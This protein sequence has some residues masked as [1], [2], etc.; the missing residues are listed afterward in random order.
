MRIEPKIKNF[1][2]V[3]ISV[4]LIISSCI[5]RETSSDLS[6]I[7]EGASGMHEE[8]SATK[9]AEEND[10]TTNE[11][12]SAL[13]PDNTSSVV[14]SPTN[15]TDLQ[16]SI[17]F[18]PFFPSIGAISGNQ[19]VF[20]VG[21]LTGVHVYNA[22]TKEKL[23]TIDVELPDCRYGW[24][25]YLALDHTGEFVS[26]VT[27]V[28]VEVWQVGGGRIFQSPFEHQRTLDPLTCGLDVPQIALS[29]HGKLLAESGFGVGGE[30]YGDYFR[31]TDVDK[32]EVVYSW[33][34]DADKAHG[35]LQS[36]QALGF[37][38]DGRFIHTFDPKFFQFSGTDRN[39]GFMFWS[40]DNWQY[41]ASESDLV[42]NSFP[43]RNFFYARSDANFVTISDKS[44]NE[45]LL[46]F[47]MEGCTREY[48]C[49]VIFSSDGSKFGVL[50]ASGEIQYKRET[51]ITEIDIFDLALGKKMNSLEILARNKNNLLLKDN[52]DII[53]THQSGSDNSTWWTHIAYLNALF[54]VGDEW[55]G[56]TP[57]VIDVFSDIPQYA[58]TCRIDLTSYSLTCSEGIRQ[59]DGT[60]LSIDKISGGFVL[61]EHDQPIAQVKY[62]GGNDND[63][64]QIRLKGFNQHTG[65]GYFCLDRN[66]REETC[67]VMNFSDNR[68]ILE[69]VDLFGFVHSIKNGLS[70]FID[71]DNKELNIFYEESSRTTQMHSYQAIAYPLRPVLTA[72]DER[73]FYVV[74]NVEN[75]RLYIEEIS[76]LD[77]KVVKRFDFNSPPD[78]QP[79]AIAVNAHADL[80]VLG[81]NGGLIYVLDLS[82]ND[83]I[84]TMTVSNS[85]I[86]D[87][88][89]SGNDKH[90]IVMD[91]SGEINVL[92][93]LDKY[94]TAD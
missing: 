76:L 9:P 1:P 90:L 8:S 46:E 13:P 49:D 24:D 23:M 82:S 4:F 52:G 61:L 55:I 70:V 6:T 65:T 54:N 3:A 33:D 85:E 45:E 29:P 92:Q 27:N 22:N 41:V 10:S 75:K 88:I 57:Q 34:G 83:L 7:Q 63:T 59:P 35:Q 25:A 30:E 32:K 37:S 42:M 48:P 28:G 78:I 44:S 79:T 77:A 17:Q 50:K 74:Q 94:K 69:Q 26:F 56:F 81:D 62:P 11:T 16:T 19:E 89:F 31:V 18:Y 2:I 53:A 86:V 84:H 60:I 39:D 5:G 91:A 73:A 68:I 14:I 43:A 21:D 36:F 40:T 20:A 58:G 87:L 72:G 64:W 93:V 15:V 67:V 71:R 51:L 12:K 66:L 47:E 38:A 80:I